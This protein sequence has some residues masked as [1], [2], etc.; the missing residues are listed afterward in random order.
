M[1]IPF[2]LQKCVYC[3]FV[4]FAD[5]ADKFSAYADAVAAQ[6]ETYAEKC[7]EKIFDTVYFGGGTPSVLP[8]FLI[9]KIVRA[10]KSNFNI[11]KNA[12]WTIEVNPATVDGDKAKAIKQLGFNR[13]SI[14]MQSADDATLRFLGRAHNKKQ[15]EETVVLLQSAD[16]KNINAD[17]ILG[18]P[19]QNAEVVADTVRYLSKLGV[20]HISAYSLILEKGTPL[21]KWVKEGSIVLPD[22]DFTVDLYDAFV[23]QAENE[24]YKRYE[25]SNFAADGF[26]SRH[27]VSCWDYNEY[28]GLGASAQSFM[29]DRRFTNVR[30]L[31]NFIEK[32][33]NRKSVIS[34]CKKLSA[35]E[36]MFEFVMLGLRLERGLD[37]QKFKNIFGRDF[38]EY[39]GNI[40]E[41]LQKQN[42]A[43]V[44][45][46]FFKVKK[47]KFYILNSVITE[48]I[49]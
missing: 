27:N 47:E 11:D 4:S 28:L 30:G 14:G 20:K 22:D 25:V 29:F 37:A 49:I 24:G 44:D 19:N 1:H 15:F 35:E 23:N 42:L 6:A 43:E 3:D 48:F 33:A 17:F 36:K 16:I 5:R 32:A 46:A 10:L 8:A 2:C 12:E 34:S 40:I 13:V 9:E 45:G 18:L 21:Y 31:D 7:R 26:C 39:Y 38:F 41:R